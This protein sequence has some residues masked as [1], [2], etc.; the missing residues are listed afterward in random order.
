MNSLTFLTWSWKSIAQINIRAWGEGAPRSAAMLWVTPFSPWLLPALRRTFVKAG[1]KGG[2][3]RKKDGWAWI[4]AP[5]KPS[6]PACQGYASQMSDPP[7]TQ[8]T[9]Q[10]D[11]LC[12][13][14][15]AFLASR[16]LRMKASASVPC[17]VFQGMKTKS[18]SSAPFLLSLSS[19]VQVTFSY[20]ISK[21][22]ALPCSPSPQPPQR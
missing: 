15:F 22:P 11:Y 6:S 9:P 18:S 3:S 13:V 2:G 19:F 4:C 16:N 17:I 21:A 20:V 10:L 5:W 12:S 7:C 14:L 8:T 1:A